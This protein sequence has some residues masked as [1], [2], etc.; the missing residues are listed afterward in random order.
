MLANLTYINEPMVRI[1]Y[2]V[3]QQLLTL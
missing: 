1:R 2:I 3:L